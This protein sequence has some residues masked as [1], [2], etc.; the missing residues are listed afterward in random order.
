MIASTIK[1]LKDV[2]NVTIYIENF[3]Y[4]I[5]SKS[6]T[7]GMPEWIPKRQIFYRFIV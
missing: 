1:V 3:K 2:S 4:K 6:T 5:E 7:L